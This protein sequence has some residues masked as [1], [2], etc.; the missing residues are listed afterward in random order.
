VEKNRRD[1]ITGEW[2]DPLGDWANEAPADPPADRSDSG[3]AAE[4]NDSGGDGGRDTPRDPGIDP[5]DERIGYGRPP[6]KYR[7]KKG[8][9]SANPSGRPKGV[10]NE[11]TILNELLEEKIQIRVG[12]RIRTVSMRTAMLMRFRDEALKGD[13][14]SASFILN[15]QNQHSSNEPAQ[16]ET[17]QN[18]QEVI[19]TF[20]RRALRARKGESE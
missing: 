2:D 13:I 9:S 4:G 11:A 17:N 5:D 15:R 3:S 7:Y 1:P 16:P 12:R 20:L 18:D 14:K 6:K 10:K 8:Q 19:E